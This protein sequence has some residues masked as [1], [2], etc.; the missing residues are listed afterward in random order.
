MLAYKVREPDAPKKKKKEFICIL[1][2]L[3]FHIHMN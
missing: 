2:G 3:N 1:F